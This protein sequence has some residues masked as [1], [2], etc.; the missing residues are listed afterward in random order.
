MVC[1]R[2][3]F[4]LLLLLGCP[5]CSIIFLSW[6]WMHVSYCM[7]ALMPAA[8]TYRRVAKRFST[9]LWEGKL[10]LLAVWSVHSGRVCGFTPASGESTAQLCPYGVGT[11]PPGEHGSTCSTTPFDLD[12]TNSKLAVPSAT[13]MSDGHG[14]PASDCGGACRPANKC[15]AV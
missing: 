5:C 1:Q 15:G 14:T 8:K 11:F 2:F 6:W 9:K 7:V 10:L 3:C 4:G 12:G 13:C